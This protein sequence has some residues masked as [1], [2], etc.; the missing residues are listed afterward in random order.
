M[1]KKNIKKCDQNQDYSC[2]IL[3]VTFQKSIYLRKAYRDSSSYRMGRLQ[4]GLGAVE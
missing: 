4:V 2:P 3:H 1:N